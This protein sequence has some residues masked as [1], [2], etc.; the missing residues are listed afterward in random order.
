MKQPARREFIRSVLQSCGA[1]ATYG[2]AGKLHG[3]SANT[4]VPAGLEWREEKKVNPYDL[5]N[6]RSDEE[7]LS[8]ARERI[9]EVRK[10]HFS[11]R[12][13]RED[14]RPLARTQ[15][16]IRQKDHTVD[17][18]YSVAGSKAKMNLDERS[19]SRDRH[20][21]K[22]FDCTT[23]KCYWNERWHQPI[24]QEQGIRV[25]DRFLDEVEWAK[26]LGLKVKGHP[27]VW[28][29]SK[30]IPKWLF[31]YDYAR[32]VE[33]L[34]Q[35]VES[36]VEVGGSKVEMWDLCNEMLWEPAFRNIAKRSWPHLDPIPDIAEYIA[37]AFRWARE[38][39]DQ[40][41]YS[42]ND[43]GLVYTNRQDISA[44]QQRMRYLELAEELKRLGVQPDAIGCQAHIGGKFKLDA[45][46]KAIDELAQSRLPVQITEFW[47]KEKDFSHL[48][49]DPSELEKALA[50]YVCSIYTVAFSHPSVSHFTYWGGDQFFDQ[51]GEPTLL[52]R[53]LHDLIKG[54]WTTRLTAST[55]DQGKLSFVGFKGNYQLL[56]SDGSFDARS[57]DLSSDV[58]ATVRIL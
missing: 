30:A 38:S 50:N 11:I 15:L 41:L 14:G 51:N 36:L 1:L 35:H 49:E 39:N 34:R 17:W 23:A 28:T 55:D 9:E 7:V 4:S 6:L 8:E 12:M 20:F 2:A 40:A 43:Y 21:A 26:A 45:F 31:G 52:Y 56:A 3:A 27:L 47:S 13:L 16:Q 22:L 32:Q 25:Y 57:I 5:Q 24:E 37:Q 54:Q 44:H 46:R 19:R 42:L 18:G 53:K 33:F 29:V 10:G 48:R 58:R